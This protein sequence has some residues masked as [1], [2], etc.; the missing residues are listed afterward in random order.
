[1]KFKEAAM[2][3]GHHKVHFIKPEPIMPHVYRDALDTK[4][5]C[6]D[7]GAVAMAKTKASISCPL[8]LAGFSKTVRKMVRS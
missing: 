7:R 6:G 8:C 3:A 5:F 1:M 4:A 2:H